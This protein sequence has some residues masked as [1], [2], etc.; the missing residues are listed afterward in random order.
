MVELSP[1]HTPTDG[2][3]PM[4]IRGSGPRIDQ[5]TKRYSIVGMG[6]DLESRC[7][8]TDAETE[9]RKVLDELRTYFNT[10]IV[11]TVFAHVGAEPPE[12]SAEPVYQ[13]LT[14][15]DPPACDETAVRT[16]LDEHG[17]D[18]DALAADFV[19]TRTMY[20]YLRDQRGHE[21]PLP[22]R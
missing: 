22:L 8:Q 6:A 1:H 15:D 9:P 20:R 11:R 4:P 17:V 3:Y 16:W 12:H 14:A 10:A 5:L 21:V 13:N 2:V 7:T 19:S 18:P